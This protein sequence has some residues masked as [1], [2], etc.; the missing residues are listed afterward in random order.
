MR[1]LEDYD[2]KYQT[3]D[4][5]RSYGRGYQYTS[6][7]KDGV[8]FED[9]QEHLFNSSSQEDIKQSQ[10]LQSSPDNNLT[11]SSYEASLAN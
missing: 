10:L 1:S 3:D 7:K 4:F 11:Y 6:S 8:S 5:E 9:S 2:S